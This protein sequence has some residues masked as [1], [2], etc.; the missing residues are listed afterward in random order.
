M[1][2]SVHVYQATYAMSKERYA[3]KKKYNTATKLMTFVNENKNKLKKATGAFGNI[4]K[5]IECLEI[6]VECYSKMNENLS[7]SYFFQLADMVFYTL[8][9]ILKRSVSR[10][11]SWVITVV[12]KVAW[13]LEFLFESAC[14]DLIELIFNKFLKKVKPWFAN[15]L[16]KE[17]NR[18]TI[19]SC[20]TALFKSFVKCF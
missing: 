18:L 10:F 1:L 16:D 12:L 20:F 15:Y 4:G 7:R 3:H 11:V 14:E 2:V 13:W 9:T 19:G 8:R 6:A 5:A 17:K